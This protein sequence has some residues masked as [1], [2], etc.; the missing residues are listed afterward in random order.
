MASRNDV[1]LKFGMAAEAAQ[2]LE[3]SLGT[4]LLGLEGLRRGWPARPQ[5]EEARAALERVEKSTLGTLLKSMQELVPFE[6]D[7]LASLFLSAL[8]TRNKLMHGFYERYNSKIHTKKGRDM[9]IAHLDLMHRELFRASQMARAIA[10]L[11]RMQTKLQS[12]LDFE[13]M[14]KQSLEVLRVFIEHG[15][16][17][18]VE[19]GPEFI[20]YA[21]KHWPWLLRS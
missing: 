2:S 4:A 14:D 5:P 6:D 8:K 20:T 10:A 12:K 7:R 1:N 16:D 18:V 11:I 15:G 21:E 3:T 13:N 9:M 17:R 19:A